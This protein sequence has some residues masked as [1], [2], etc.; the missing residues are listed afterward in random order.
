MKVVLLVVALMMANS[1]FAAAAKTDVCHFTNGTPLFNLINV[2]DP[3]IDSH[4]EHGD[5]LIGEPVPGMPGFVFNEVCDAIPEPIQDPFLRAIAWIDVDAN[6]RYDE[7]TDGLVARLRDEGG[8][9]TVETAY[10]LESDSDVNFPQYWVPFAVEFH[11]GG[12]LS[13]LLD[14]Y[15]LILGDFVFIWQA[16]ETFERYFERNRFPAP[17]EA[18]VVSL[19]DYMLPANPA[20]QTTYDY[21]EIACDSPSKAQWVECG[22]L[23]GGRSFTQGEGDEPFVQVSIF[24]PTP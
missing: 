23:L 5:A 17:G 10:T 20:D 21:A 7:G 4:I 1:A 22:D 9:P 15:R 3:A 16:N 6:G 19:F 12:Q 11:E 2:A 18:G 13:Q 24:F 14:G 8:I